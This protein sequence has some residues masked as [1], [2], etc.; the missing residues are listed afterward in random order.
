MRP[1]WRTVPAPT[2]ST[3]AASATSATIARAL[4]PWL[5]ICRTTESASLLLERT[6]TTTAAPP[7]ASETAMAWPIL[8]PA[9]VTIATRPDSSFPSLTAQFLQIDG[10][11]V[12]RLRALRRGAVFPPPP[13]AVA[14]I[15]RELVLDIGAR[16]RL[17]GAAAEM[18]LA[19][20]HNATIGERHA[21]VAGE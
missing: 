10:P 1:N 19:L 13:P 2:A 15:E 6:L 14:A 16:Q 3:A 4:P 5:S 21:D 18:R 9:P 12:Q 17:P 11:V 8:R 20:L 7:A